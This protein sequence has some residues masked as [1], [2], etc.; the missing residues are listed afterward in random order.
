MHSGFLNLSI[1]CK[2]WAEILTCISHRRWQLLTVHKK[3]TTRKIKLDDDDPILINEILH[4]L[5]KANYEDPESRI[6]KKSPNVCV[7]D[8]PDH[9]DRSFSDHHDEHNDI[10]HLQEAD[11]MEMQPPAELHARM[12]AIGDKYD[13][14]GLR[15]CVKE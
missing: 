14:T 7:R 2:R 11:C 10:D 4:Y 5:Y 12:Y 15:E 9:E 3:T 13:V 6:E 1:S 8:L